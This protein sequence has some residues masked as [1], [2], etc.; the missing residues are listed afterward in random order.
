[1]LLATREEQLRVDTHHAASV[2]QAK[3][4]NLELLRTSLEDFH[5]HHISFSRKQVERSTPLGYD[6]LFHQVIGRLRHP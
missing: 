5:R 3:H 4:L 1:M 2:Q 6:G